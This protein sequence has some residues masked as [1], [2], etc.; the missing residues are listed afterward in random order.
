MTDTRV[1][2]AKP[3]ISGAKLECPHP[4]R[5]FVDNVN[6]WMVSALAACFLYAF[7]SGGGI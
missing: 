5:R 6:E 2:V 7:L 1:K 3:E 4:T